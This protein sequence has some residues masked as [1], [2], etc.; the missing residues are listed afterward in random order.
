ME[1]D[2]KNRVLLVL[3]LTVANSVERRSTSHFVFP[4]GVVPSFMME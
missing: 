1:P 2:H 3:L 4:L